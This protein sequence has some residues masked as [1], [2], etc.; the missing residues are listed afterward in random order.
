MSA[1]AVAEAQTEF[2]STG[3]ALTSSAQ[4][5]LDD[6][7]LVVLLSSEMKIN[8]SYDYSTNL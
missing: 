2:S 6:C 3:V 1:E 4:V 5:C 7:G 8:V